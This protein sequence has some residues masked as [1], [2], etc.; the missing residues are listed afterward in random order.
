MQTV[1]RVI[2]YATTYGAKIL[3]YILGIILLY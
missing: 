2:M 1:V 3:D